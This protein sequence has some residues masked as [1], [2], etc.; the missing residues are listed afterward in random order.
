MVGGGQA[1]GCAPRGKVA[2]GWPA[3]L[4]L[5]G[6]LFVTTGM[7]VVHLSIHLGLLAPRLAVSDAPASAGHSRAVVPASAPHDPC[8]VCDFLLNF[9]AGVAA[10][11]PAGLEPASAGVH[12]LLPDSL[13]PQQLAG[14]PIGP[15]APPT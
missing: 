13:I 8:L 1:V 11:T 4:A 14:P 9:Q 12:A 15:R 7:H 10:A 2:T 5:A 6:M 3:F